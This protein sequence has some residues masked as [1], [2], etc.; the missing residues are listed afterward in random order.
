MDQGNAI[1]VLDRAKEEV[2]RRWNALEE[3]AKNSRNARDRYVAQMQMQQVLNERRELEEFKDELAYIDYEYPAPN[4][5][6]YFPSP[7]GQ[8]VPVG[9]RPS[10]IE[11]YGLTAEDNPLNPISA[12][13]PETGVEMAVTSAYRPV[14]DMPTMRYLFGQAGPRM[15][16]PKLGGW[17]ALGTGLIDQGLNAYRDIRRS[18]LNLPSDHPSEI[19]RTI[20]EQGW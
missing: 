8:Q 20:K 12:V 15:S 10:T 4:P 3:R 2:S 19:A 14:R 11:S 1:N 5:Y 13:V 9:Y 7:D 6:V 18:S 17:A 16:M